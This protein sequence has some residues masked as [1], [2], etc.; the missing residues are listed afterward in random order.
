MDIAIVGTGYVG[1]T[2]GTC[3]AALGHRVRC[4]DIDAKKVANLKRGALPIFEAGLGE[5]VVS[6]QRAGNLHFTDDLADAVR[7]AQIV[8][9]SVGTPPGARGDVDLSF[10]ECAVD[11]VAPHLGQGAVLVIKSTV[12][13]GTAR[14]IKH[15]LG[16]YGKNNPVA[17]NP[18]FLREGSAVEDF[19][20]PDRIVIGADE[21][22]A[23]TA[24]VRLYAPFK[25]RGVPVLTT[26]TVDAELTKYAANAFLA[27]KI[28][29][30]NE[31]ADLCEQT[32]GDVSAVATCIGHDK[33]IGQAFL[34][35][36]PGFGGS[37]F[38]KDTR[39]FIA[40]GRRFGA[41]QSLVES[42]VRSNDQRKTRLANRILAQLREP[43]RSTVAVLGTAFKTGT[44]DMREAAALTI[45]PLLLKNGVTVKAHDPQ[46][47]RSGED[48]L[49]GV[50]W[51]DNPLAAV[52]NADVTVILT[53]WPDYRSL[54]FHRIA[55]LMR[56]DLLF[57]YRNLLNA[58]DVTAAGLRYVSLG[59]P[60]RRPRKGAATAGDWHDIAAAPY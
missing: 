20:H 31:V 1:L 53:E 35:P 38:P 26:S 56:G 15:Q 32:G 40:T 45:L 12:P 42:L 58:T 59:R 22:A 5:L 37:C 30:I 60:I 57:D 46:S 28:G 13:A 29:F 48:L 19:F 10:V 43:A 17:S 9:I 54:E 16:R 21:P 36:G 52:T 44:D 7:H 25:S 6:S 23:A 50:L 4:V 3:L 33:R 55:S 24:L 34:S 49:P 51:Q 27:L 14:Q 18:E 41:S 47:R 11:D 39:A 2:T 8:F